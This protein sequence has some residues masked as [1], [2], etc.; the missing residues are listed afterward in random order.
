L[1]ILRRHDK[2]YFSE[3]FVKIVG[4]EGFGKAAARWSPP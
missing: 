1:V 2:T 4:L 3:E